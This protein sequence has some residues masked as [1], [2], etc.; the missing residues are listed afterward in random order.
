MKT[1]SVLR[2][3]AGKASL[4]TGLAA[5]A[6]IVALEMQSQSTSGSGSFIPPLSSALSSHALVQVTLALAGMGFIVAG[7]KL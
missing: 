3:N 1:V 4:L 2:K 7:L 6:T 5:M